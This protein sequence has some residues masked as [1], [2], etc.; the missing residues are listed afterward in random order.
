MSDTS[1]KDKHKPL[2]T[3]SGI[4]LL[5]VKTNLDS[6]YL[7]DL[8]SEP[9]G[10]SDPEKILRDIKSV[11][12][13]EP[14]LGVIFTLNIVP[15]HMVPVIITKEDK[16]EEKKKGVTFQDKLD[17]PRTP[18]TH[19]KLPNEKN[20]SI[21][22]SIISF[23]QNNDMDTSSKINPDINQ[24]IVNEWVRQFMS[25]RIQCCYTK[26]I[27]TLLDNKSKL[28]IVKYKYP[29]SDI[30]LFELNTKKI[31]KLKRS[32]KKYPFKFNE[33][34]F[35]SIIQHDLTQPLFILL[36]VDNSIYNLICTTNNSVFYSYFPIYSDKKD[37]I[38]IEIK[39][40]LEKEGFSYVADKRRKIDEFKDFLPSVNE[41]IWQEDFCIFLLLSMLDELLPFDEI[42]E[43]K[44]TRSEYQQLYIELIGF[45]MKL[46]M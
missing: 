6:D 32:T 8:F 12:E 30:I 46:L 29:D 24:S 16:I 14:T 43:H 40:F 1:E 22:E 26:D 34:A 13:E 28:D 9:E 42:R 4:P 7:L 36:V 33:D 21:L 27:N 2:I 18:P 15:Y 20:P 39:K 37:Y 41:S 3:K 35:Y 19:I 10:K 44:I 23:I 45:A 25:S 17:Q 38:D 5:R 11:E 31:D